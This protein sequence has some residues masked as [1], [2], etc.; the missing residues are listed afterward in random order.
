VQSPEAT[1]FLLGIAA[2]LSMAIA[3]VL[4]GAISKGWL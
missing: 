4:V 2:G 3:L 1:A